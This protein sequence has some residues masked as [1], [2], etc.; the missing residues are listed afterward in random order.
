MI[1]SGKD[2]VRRSF[3]S[4]NSNDLETY[5]Q[6]LDDDFVLHDQDDQHDIRG[7]R[8][9]AEYFRQ[10]VD[11][12]PSMTIDIIDQVSEGDLVA[13]RWVARGTHEGELLGIKPTNKKITVHG[14][15]F[16]RVRNGKIVETWQNWDSLGLFT[17]LGEM[18]SVA[19]A[20]AR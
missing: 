6:L 15:E 8:A 4:I 7:A 11:A 9:G 10:Y 16:D 2:V 19:S 18:P 3:E 12:F 17:Q 20:P 5:E 13:T 1:T 14:I